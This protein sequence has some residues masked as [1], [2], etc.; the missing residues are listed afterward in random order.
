VKTAS[1]N[2]PRAS[3]SHAA[4]VHAKD[5]IEGVIA[6]QAHDPGG[7]LLPKILGIEHAD[8]LTIRSLMLDPAGQF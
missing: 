3:A 6:A 5:E 7:G 8:F 1:A 4:P 2:S